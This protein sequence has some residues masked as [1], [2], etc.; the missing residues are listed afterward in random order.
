MLGDGA[1]IERIMN[2]F[3]VKALKCLQAA[4]VRDCVKR[5]QMTMPQI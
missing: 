3:I 2:I 1:E 5:H 4:C